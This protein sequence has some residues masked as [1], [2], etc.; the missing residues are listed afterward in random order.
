M[1]F[2]KTCNSPINYMFIYTLS[3]KEHKVST[4]MEP[5]FYPF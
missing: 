3:V 5:I 4:N 2:S 1:L